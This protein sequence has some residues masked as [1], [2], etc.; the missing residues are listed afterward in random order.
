MDDYVARADRAGRSVGLHPVT[1][2]ELEPKGASREERSAA[3][4]A[5]APAGARRIVLDE[6]GR[7]LAS[8]AFACKLTDLRDAGARDAAFVI[9]EADGL[10]EAARAQADFVLAFGPQTWP[11]RLVRVM[12]A[13]QIYRAIAILAGSPYHRGGPDAR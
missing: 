12:L 3:L 13:E 4:L 10:T 11:H 5:A 9:G 8:D 6:R 1:E 2:L 7:A